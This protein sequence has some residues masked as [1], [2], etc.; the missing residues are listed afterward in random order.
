M[1]DPSRDAVKNGTRSIPLVSVSRPVSSLSCLLAA[2]TLWSCA[3]DPLSQVH[4][5]IS[6]DPEALDFG[7]GIVGRDNPGALLVLNRGSAALI[8]EDVSIEPADGVFRVSNAPDVVPVNGEAPL[9]LVFV[10]VR[11]HQRSD[12]EL[13]LTS[14]DPERP[15]LRVPLTGVG[16]VREIEV[17]PAEIDF[18]VVNEG[19]PQ[20]RQVEIRNIG[21]DPLAIDRI[22]FTST[23]I[24]LG[25]AAD[26]FLAGVIE[27]GTSTTVE[28]E[29]APQDLGA[30][31]GILTI[32]SD[33][34]DEPEVEVPV[35]GLANLAPRAIAWGCAPA[36][37]RIGCEGAPDRSRVFS[38][39]LRQR[40]NLDGRE[41]FDPEGGAIASY[42]WVLEARPSGSSA[43]IFHS[44]DDRN[45]RNRATGDLEVDVA[46]TYQLR[47]I[48]RDD[49]GLESLDRPE[50]RITLRPKDLE[51]LLRWD[52]T[53][54]VDLHVVRPGGRVG[55]YG[56]GAVGTST[57]SD[58]S[59]FNRRP[60]W[61]DLATSRDDPSL[62]IDDVTGRGPEVVS[63]DQ[64]E[65]DGTYEV[66]VHYC[67]SRNVG[68]GAGVTLE[69]HV[70]G[71]LVATVP[72]F[73]LAP[74]EVWRGATVTWRET[75]GTPSAEVEDGLAERPVMN[76]GLCRSR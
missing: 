31:S 12:A 34:E 6:T 40:I 39:G 26:T 55:D 21:G 9:E 1:L 25:L 46:G 35:R 74:G 33:D 16:G 65:V 54:D 38:T 60:N 2:V 59:T 41:S 24:D 17:L 42:R 72:S 10:P 14:N 8:L 57:G 50:S 29:Y 76:P 73:T 15:V 45:L 3:D 47:L 44:T 71:E 28:L 27:P 19:A 58:V 20:R 37:M 68:V 22:V 36:P 67:D 48:A 53:T 66:F 56:T 13:V 64:P 52:V 11:A 30:D 61:G 63:L 69:I 75:A 18:G 4:P 7:A 62:D 51:V 5:Q 49:R 70:R 32:F 23:S 43:A